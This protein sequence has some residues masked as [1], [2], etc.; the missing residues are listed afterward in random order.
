MSDSHLTHHHHSEPN[1]RWLDLLAGRV[2]G[3]SGYQVAAH[4]RAA[5]E[6]LRDAIVPKLTE[7]RGRIEEAIRQ[8]EKRGA[9]TAIASIRRLEAHLDRILDRPRHVGHTHDRFYSAATLD[10][11]HAD[12]LHAIDLE[13]LDLAEKFHRDFDAPDRDHDRLARLEQDLQRLDVKLDQRALML[14]AIG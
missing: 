14:G 7:A 11:K 10:Q 2:P 3:Y 8:C 12:A 9:E 6:A 4:R 5:E 1:L 13:I